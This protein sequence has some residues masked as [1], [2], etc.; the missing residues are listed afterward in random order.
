MRLQNAKCFSPCPPGYDDALSRALP[1]V[2]K[3]DWLAP[4]TV[5]DLPLRDIEPGIA[6]TIAREAIG[7]AAIV[8]SMILNVGANRLRLRMRKT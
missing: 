3:P 8:A 6:E 4:D 5:C 2:G 1:A 7:G